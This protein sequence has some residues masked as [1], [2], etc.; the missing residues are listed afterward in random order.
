ME[1]ENSLVALDTLATELDVSSTAAATC[2][3]PVAVWASRF[4]DFAHHLVHF[5]DKIVHA[6]GELGH[7]VPAL[8]RQTLG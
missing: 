7:F 3:E 5:G 8:H 2:D 4:R 6:L 1:A